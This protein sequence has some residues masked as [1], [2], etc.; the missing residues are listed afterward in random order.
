M[1]ALI[2]PSPITAIEWLELFERLFATAIP[3]VEEIE[4]E[5]CAAPKVSYSLSDLFV[6]PDK[7]PP[8]LKVLIFF[9]LPVIILW[10]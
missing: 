4:V 9:L 10:G 8:F 2:A 6:K 5:L 3:K 1:P 7:P